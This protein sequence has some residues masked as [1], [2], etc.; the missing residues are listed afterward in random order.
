MKS[1]TKLFGRSPF[2]HVVEHGAKVEEC[3]SKLTGV[4]SMVFEGGEPEKIKAAA[5][6]VADLE[7]EADAIRNKIHEALSGKLLLSVSRGELFDIVEQQDSM[8]DRAEEI[9]A[10]FTFRPLPLPEAIS[11]EVKRFAAIVLQNCAI[12]AGVVSK[13]ELLIE[14]SFA[15]RDTGTVLKLIN[16]L[17]ERDDPTRDAGLAATRKVYGADQALSPVEIMLWI[18]I[19]GLLDDL[20]GF[21]DCTAN[22]LRIVIENQRN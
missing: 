10:S 15:N 17:R 4:I 19:I 1:I 6:E 22:G 5:I 11:A 20:S 21:A 18:K 3:L 16:E 12:A 8:A 2:V 7:T 9:A 13:F 14:S